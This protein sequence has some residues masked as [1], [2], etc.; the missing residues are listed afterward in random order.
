MS[1]LPAMPSS[2]FVLN[3]VRF[4]NARPKLVSVRA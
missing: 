4:R 3:N 1:R 2:G